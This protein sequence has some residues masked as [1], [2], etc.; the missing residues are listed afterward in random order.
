MMGLLVPAFLVGLAAVLV[1]VLLHL[2]HRERREAM[3]FPSLMFLQRIPFRS[4][5][6]QKLVHLLLLAVRGAA[7]ALLALAFA[8]PLLDTSAAAPPGVD[9][10]AWARVVLLDT[11]YS[12]AYG[13]RWARAQAAARAEID[14]LGPED[15]GAVVAFSDRAHDAVALTRDKAALLAAVE[16]SRPGSRVTRF[17]PALKLAQEWL[18]GAAEPRREVVLVSDL[19]KSGW[20]AGDDVRLPPGTS[21]RPIPVAAGEP[22]NVALTELKLQRDYAEGRERVLA[23]V[24]VASKGGGR[25]VG[26]AVTLELGGR[27][28]EVKP[29]SLAAVAASTAA[30]QPFTFPAGVTRGTVRITSDALAADDARYFVLAPG[31]AVSVLVVIADAASTPAGVYLTGALAI[32]DRPRFRADVRPRGAVSAADVSGR[33]V[34]VL[35]DT[36]ALAEGAVR[37]VRA[38]LESGGGL[39]IVL[40]DRAS[41]AGWPG[42]LGPAVD[43]TA[44]RGATLG[45]LDYDHPA[46]VLFKGP[47]SGD[48]SAPRFLRYRRLAPSDGARVL[49]RFDD[50]APALVEER[51]GRGRVLVFASGLDGR[52]NDLPLRPVFLPLLHQLVKYAAGRADERTSWQVG[53]VVEVTRSRA[54][55]VITVVSPSGDRQRLDAAQR[56]LELEEAG[57]YEIRTAEGGRETTTTLAVNVDTTES[58]L[59]ALDPDEITRAVTRASATSPAAVRAPETPEEREARQALWWY[60]LAA[61]FLALVAETLLSNRLSRAVG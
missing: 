11:S 34:V 50:G 44:D 21:F 48:F 36:P 59:T 10:G 18:A 38:H 40:G 23:S 8:R 56:Y 12:M 32:G 42:T 29:V 26:P 49:A 4:V 57:F 30:F 7:L 46:L 61:V 16:A 47:K 2:R 5:R 39:L 9:Q 6:R 22:V 41:L 3:P 13:D 14:S 20:D 25:A 43:R 28:V 51:V 27:T 33:A 58:D 53:D 45:F 54:D 17:A 19:Q 37:A 15:A 31:Q 55:A 52:W 60:A 35:N 1:P 24:R